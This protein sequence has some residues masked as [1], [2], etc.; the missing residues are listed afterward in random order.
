MLEYVWMSLYSDVT[1]CYPTR[2]VV[3]ERAVMVGILFK[4]T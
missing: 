2:V 3:L 1:R 4:E